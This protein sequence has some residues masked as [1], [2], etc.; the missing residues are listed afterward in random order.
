MERIPVRTLLHTDRCHL[1]R[2]V[3]SIEAMLAEYDRETI[4][5]V[6]DRFDTTAWIQQA[7]EETSELAAALNKLNRCLGVGLST[8]ADIRDVTAHVIEEYAD[9]IGTMETA[10]RKMCEDE[11][12][13]DTKSE[14]AVLKSD[15]DAIP[16]G[17]RNVKN[18][19]GYTKTAKKIRFME[20][21]MEK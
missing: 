1:G 16:F 11:R 21:N 18:V 10:L 12:F 4:E 2:A 6:E 19:I 15:E 8:P 7:S 14:N 20:R 5:S 17:M 9:V 13:I 3:E